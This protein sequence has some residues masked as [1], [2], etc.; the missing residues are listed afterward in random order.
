MT[1]N[2]S[3]IGFNPGRS[4]QNDIAVHAEFVVTTDLNA[5]DASSN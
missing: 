4:F 2:R 3:V 5:A 1:A